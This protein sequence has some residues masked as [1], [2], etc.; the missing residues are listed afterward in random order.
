MV[1][2]EARVWLCAMGGK[3]M[4]KLDELMTT[5]REKRAAHVRAIDARNLAR[6]VWEA[7][8]AEERTAAN[9]LRNA[10]LALWTEIGM[11]PDGLTFFLE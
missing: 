6:Q 5:Y 2:G 1:L 11:P 7:A 9:E 10:S 8:Q 3:G 4:S